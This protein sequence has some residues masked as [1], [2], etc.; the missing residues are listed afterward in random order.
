EGLNRPGLD[1][2]AAYTY[3]DPK[4]GTEFSGAVGVTFNTINSFTDYRSGTD[5]HLEAGVIQHFNLESKVFQQFQIG[6]GGYFYQQVSPDGG[7]GDRIGPL[8][9]RVAAVG[10]I[11]G[12]TL[13]VGETPVTVNARWFHE[14]DVKNRFAGDSVF[15]TMSVPL[16]VY[17]LEIA[18]AN[19]A[20]AAARRSANVY[21]APPAAPP[22]RSWTGFY[23]GANAGGVWSNTDIAWKA[24]PP[25]F[26]GSASAID[27]AGT[28]TIKSSGF[29]GGGQVG[30]NYQIQ[31]ALFGV[32][33]DYDYTGLSG[34]RITAAI[35]AVGLPDPI[36]ETFSSNFLATFRTRVGF[37]SGPWL[38]YGTA[39]VASARVHYSDRIE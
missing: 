24:N 36:T 35:P 20:Q 6:A 15:L 33:A 37:A 10:P 7:S 9:G 26:P 21:K 39:G 30:F 29:T 38:L 23:V 32:E 17:A 22:D 16:Q 27:A 14:F 4:V 2:R 13:L 25:G 11:V 3:L 19:K 18:A 5:L 8:I 12:G 31:H 28:G 1:L 34:R